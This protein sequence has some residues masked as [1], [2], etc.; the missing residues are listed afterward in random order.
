MQLDDMC[1]LSYYKT[2][3]SLSD[4]HSVF[5][6]QHTET[7]KIYVKKIMTVYNI[8]VFR[9]LKDH[10]IQNTPQI[11]EI[12]E[13]QDK[14]IVIEEYLTGDS[15]Q[16]LLERQGT[17]NEE[18]VISLVRQVCAIIRHFHTA[19][20]PIVHRDI[21]PS[22]ILI[23]T[24]GVLKLLDM[25]A[26]KYSADQGGK[27]TVLIGTVG[28]AAPEQY[29]FG[30]SNIQTDIYAIGVLIN[31]LL[32]GQFPQE[33]MASGKL[34]ELIHTCIEVDWTK[35]YRSIDE[36]V[37]ELN[38]IQ[39]VDM[40]ENQSISY[41]LPGF[42]TENPIK[43]ILAGFGYF[44]MTWFC[45]NITIEPVNGSVDLWLNRIFIM[46][47]AYAEVLFLGNYRNV[48]KKLGVYKYKN[49]IYRWG[50]RILYVI[51]IFFAVMLML[52]EIEKMV[53]L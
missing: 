9:Y 37:A 47:M 48:Q 13:D 23:S 2:I 20:T 39:S 16:E 41:A 14:L 36:L 12:I 24:D 53:I 35:R 52:V 34:N 6:V 28:Y 17:F 49:L 18:Q 40:E 51:L 22:N 4:A 38:R 44:F 26:A 15:L 7:K 50:L 21:K 29:G 31:M 8:D 30:V 25:N 1:T 33:Q 27:D 10:P 43:W 46:I 3:A 19:P 11:Y 32:T 5:L 42:R 45:L